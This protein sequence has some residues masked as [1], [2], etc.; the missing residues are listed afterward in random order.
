[1]VCMHACPYKQS[2]LWQPVNIIT[3]MPSIVVL[4]CAGVFIE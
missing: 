2:W 1:M 4:R 3:C